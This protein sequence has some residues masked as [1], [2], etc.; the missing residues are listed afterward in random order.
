MTRQFGGTKTATE[1]NPGIKSKIEFKVSGACVCV[2]VVPAIA[3]GVGGL[4][5]HDGCS[6]CVPTS[7]SMNTQAMFLAA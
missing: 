5:V 4:K 2:G 1:H 6:M 3:A 7:L